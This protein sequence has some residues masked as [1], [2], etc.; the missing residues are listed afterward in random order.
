MKQTSK[1]QGVK[2]S[3]TQ[4][5]RVEDEIALEFPLNIIVNE[6]I[7]SIT[8]QTP[9]NELALARGLLFNE[10]ICKEKTADWPHQVDTDSKTGYVTTIRFQLPESWLDKSVLSKRSL[11]SVSSCGICGTT[12]LKFPEGEIIA[13]KLP[14]NVG[15]VSQLFQQ[16]ES[17][18]SA[19]KASGGIHAAAIFNASLQML[20]FAEDIGRHNAVDKCVGI[21]LEN[22]SLH[23]GK[24]LLVS[25]RVSFEIISKCFT[26]GIPYLC[27]VSAPSSLSID[28]AKELGITLAGFCREGRMTIYS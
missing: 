15:L 3:A 24:F 23:Q 18:Q 22:K 28:F 14:F 9:G 1:Y 11:L 27:A 12:Q 4:E 2:L 17:K 7:I 25:G 19:F 8:M 6:Q 5:D 13:E 26:A 20:S 21:V 10:G 16:L